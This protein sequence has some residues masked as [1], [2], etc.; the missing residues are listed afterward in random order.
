MSK[1]TRAARDFLRSIKTDGP[2]PIYFIYGEETFML[3]EALQ[4]IKDVAC[5]EGL[6]DFNFDSFQGKEIKGDTLRSCAEMLPMMAARRLVLAM[7]IQE[8]PPAEL[9]PLRDYFKDPSPTT[10]LV[11]HARTS[12]K[13][14]I[15]GRLGFF[16]D[17]KKAAETCEFKPMYENEVGP[18][19]QRQAQRRGLRLPGD[20][21]GYLIEAVGTDLTA[22]STAL[23][24]LDLF[25]GASEEPDAPRLVALDVAE[26]VI[27][28]TRSR[29]VFDL[30]DALGNRD[31]QSSLEV[32]QQMLLDGESAIGI[33]HMIARHFRI[34]VKLQDPTVRNADNKT[35]ASVARVSPFFVNDYVRQARA[36][37][38]SETAAILR[39]MLDVDVALKSSSL[40]DHVILEA[41]VADICTGSLRAAAD[42]RSA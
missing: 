17:L 39:R 41:L 9:E 30:T 34:L 40:K 22:L 27:A 31:Y 3:D 14:K 12:Q 32:L 29:S 23:D 33:S 26:N 21:V 25:L 18:F 20:V 10:C 4:A 42:H 2:A 24:K 35:K 8:V 1:Q 16:K 36:F 38:P 7:D 11:L 6:N 19:I 5:P 28:R 13:K 15:D 37:P